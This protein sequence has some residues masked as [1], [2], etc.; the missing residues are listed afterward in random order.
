MLRKSSRR[1][2]SSTPEAASARTS[3]KTRPQTKRATLST[4]W[5]SISG[6][7]LYERRFQAITLLGIVGTTGF[8]LVQAAD[9]EMIH[10][11]A[12]ALTGR[13]EHGLRESSRRMVLT[14][15]LPETLTGAAEVLN[16]RTLRRYGLDRAACRHQHLRSQPEGHV[17]RNS[18]AL[19]QRQDRDEY[20]SNERRIS[21]RCQGRRNAVPIQPKCRASSSSSKA[22]Q[23]EKK[24]KPSARVLITR[25]G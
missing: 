14:R 12:Q 13:I 16:G 20:V 7:L 11:Q 10:A 3:S 18:T 2:P 21:V 9:N 23:A 22:G 24:R 6:R 19:R 4:S 1:A 8:L 15:D 5:R 25:R 17:R